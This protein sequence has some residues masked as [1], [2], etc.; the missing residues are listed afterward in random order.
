[1]AYVKTS[2]P[3]RSQE[4]PITRQKASTPFVDNRT[5]LTAQLQQQ[6]LMHNSQQSLAQLAA[7][8]V[9]NNVTAI[10]SKTLQRTSDDELLPG[11]FAPAQLNAHAYAQGR[12]KPAIQMKE[13]A[14]VNDDAGLEA[15]ADVMG[16]KAL[17]QNISAPPQ[18]AHNISHSSSTGPVQR[19]VIPTGNGWYSTLTKTMYTTELEAYKAENAFSVEL[20]E[21]NQKLEHLNFNLKKEVKNLKANNENLAKKARASEENRN[22]EQADIAKKQLAIGIISS[23][24]EIVPILM[25]YKAVFTQVG[26]NLGD[27]LLPVGQSAL[28]QGLVTAYDILVHN[29]TTKWKISAAATGMMVLGQACLNFAGSNLVMGQTGPYNAT[30]NQGEWNSYPSDSA[31]MWQI[32]LMGFGGILT[33]GGAALRIYNPFNEWRSSR[34]KISE[35]RQYGTFQ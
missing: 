8:R 29:D 33:L 28:V 24:S 17:E 5:S 13:G 25:S 30:V 23:A 6:H 19:E 27:T 26:D 10:Q 2:K 22:L 35:G 1:M 11:K 32:G 4:L 14:L 20:L 12:V 34:Q 15:E 7:Q 9:M 21:Q 3:E 31:N 16:S 18:R